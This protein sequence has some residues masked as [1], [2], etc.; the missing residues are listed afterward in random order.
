MADFSYPPE[1]TFVLASAAGSMAGKVSD[2][3]M[4]ARPDIG[5]SRFFVRNE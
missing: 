1:K 3:E 4:P 5:G 2:D